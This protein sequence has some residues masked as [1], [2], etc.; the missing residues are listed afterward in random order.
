MVPFWAINQCLPFLTLSKGCGSP[1]AGVRPE[2]V[3][4]T[5]ETAIRGVAS[6]A[7][8]AARLKFGS[9]EACGN[10]LLTTGSSIPSA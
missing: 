4:R 3:F 1:E 10:P 8:V 9:V 7:S 5:C 2:E 6:A